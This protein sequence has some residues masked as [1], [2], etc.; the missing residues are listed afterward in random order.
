MNTHAQ[1]IRILLVE[2]DEE[3]YL[4][5]RDLLSEIEGTSYD[6]EWVHSFESGLDC[7]KEHRHDINLFDYRLGRHTGLELL[8]HAVLSHCPAPTILLT[9][10]GDHGVDQTAMS[11]GAVDYLV[12]GQINAP[13]LERSIRYAL[14]RKRVEAE[15]EELNA[16]LLETARQLGMAEVATNV[17][18]DVGNVLNSV[19]A[20]GHQL[21]DNIQQSCIGDIK[22]IAEMLHQHADNIG[23]YLTHDHK[24]RQ[25]PDYL[26][27]LGENLVIQNTR[28]LDELMHL[29][30]NLDHVRRVIQTQQTFAKSRTHTEPAVPA[31][32]MDQALIINQAALDQDR[33]KV[34]RAYADLPQVMIDKHQVLQILVNLIRNASQALIALPSQ[35][36]QLTLG[37]QPCP[38]QQGYLRFQVCDTGVGIP[39]E[40]LT[41]VFAQGFTTKKDGHGFGLHGSALAAKVMNGS[42]R[43]WSDG[44]GAGATFT[45]DLPLIPVEPTTP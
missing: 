2:D 36:H 33:I 5:T 6:V 34:V 16:K 27:K 18:H 25:I 39:A 38:D 21:H 20:I 28:A 3:D 4:V 32:L 45:L 37:I 23:E 42:L 10:R 12:K 15:R 30:A 13:L 1:R 17:L 14:E 40:N 19:S 26:A 41:R 7:I 31:E 44:E 8:R 43:A 9:G 35:P 29:H 22:N 24:G 11:M